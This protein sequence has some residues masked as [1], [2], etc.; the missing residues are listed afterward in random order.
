MRCILEELE[1]AQRPGARSTLLRV[2]SSCVS[3]QLYQP[4]QS[5]DLRLDTELYV[6]EVEGTMT[7]FPASQ[8]GREPP[9]WTCC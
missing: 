8:S 7:V 2:G 6:C 3:P 5:S 4:G 9:R 1:G